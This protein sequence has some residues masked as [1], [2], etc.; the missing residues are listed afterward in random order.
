MIEILEWKPKTKSLKNIAARGIIK[1]NNFLS[2]IAPAKTAIPNSGVKFGGWGINL[3][4]AN[5]AI[6]IKIDDVLKSRNFIFLTIYNCFPN[7]NTYD[8]EYPANPSIRTHNLSL[9]KP[10]F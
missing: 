6:R 5:I 10:F 1:A 8:R 7:Y 3:L 4:N 9:H 2:N